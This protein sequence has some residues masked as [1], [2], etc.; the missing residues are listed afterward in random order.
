MYLKND[1]INLNR[2]RRDINR[3]DDYGNFNSIW[4]CSL[5]SFLRWWRYTFWRTEKE[6]MVRV[7][8]RNVSVGVWRARILDNTILVHISVNTATLMLLRKLL[9]LIG[10]L[11]WRIRRQN[12]LFQYDKNYGRISKGEQAT[13]WVRVRS[14]SAN[15]INLAQYLKKGKLLLVEG[16][17]GEPEIWEDKQHVQHVQQSIV[18]DSITFISTG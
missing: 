16:M 10:K 17:L 15:H 11:I 1:Q 4:I 13:T 18:A 3:Q 6:K 5:F 9:W 14:N 2:G 7:F 12:L 8:P